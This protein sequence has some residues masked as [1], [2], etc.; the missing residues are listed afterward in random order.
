MTRLC[1]R[2]F[3]VLTGLL[4][5]S[6][7]SD[8]VPVASTDNGD[9][10]AVLGG[11]TANGADVV[12]DGAGLADS[13]GATA[14]SG[15]S[16]VDSGT[17]TVDTAGITSDAGTSVPDSGAAKVACKSDKQCKATNEVCDPLQKACVDCLFDS[18]CGA[19]EHCTARKCTA[20]TPC[21]NSL[22]CK[23]AKSQPICAKDIKECVHIGSMNA[24]YSSPATSWSTSDLSCRT[25]PDLRHKPVKSFTQ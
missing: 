7:S 8:D 25:D 3:C 24:F 11:D 13:G 9:T 22:D 20:F 16:T 10:S 1:L 14:D 5:L 17:S 12:S 23:G 19:N 21:A 18:H 2:L 6:C 4:L 15:T